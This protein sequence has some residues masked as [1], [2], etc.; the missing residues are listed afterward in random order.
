MPSYVVLL[1]EP[2][3]PEGPPPSPEQIQ[4]TI[5]RYRAWR[6]GL[7][8][9]IRLGEKLTNEGGR[10]VRREGQAVRIT[11]GPYAEVKEGLA[12]LFI[13]EAESYD[14]A[15]KLC[16][17]CPHLDFGWIHLREVDDV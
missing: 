3:T 4:A 5:A 16:E 8:E 9:R 1:N 10:A 15:A 7:G 6:E 13:L 2:T 17:D 14:E 12:G 11:D